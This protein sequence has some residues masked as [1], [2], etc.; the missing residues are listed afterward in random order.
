VSLATPSDHGWATLARRCLDVT[1]ARARSSV[2]QH[3][4]QL[5][6]CRGSRSSEAG[7]ASTNISL[8]QRARSSRGQNIGRVELPRACGT[9]LFCRAAAA[10]TAADV[11]P[12]QHDG[13]YSTRMAMNGRS[14]PAGHQ[15]QVV[16][17]F[18]NWRFK[19]WRMV[20]MSSAVRGHGSGTLD[21]FAVR[22]NGPVGWV[23]GTSCCHLPSDHRCASPTPGKSGTVPIQVSWRSTLATC[24]RLPR[25]PGCLGRRLAW[26]RVWAASSADGLYRGG[27]QVLPA[28]AALKPGF[29]WLAS[30]AS[31]EGAAS[32]ESDS[33]ANAP[34]PRARDSPAVPTF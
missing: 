32:I 15:E 4:R 29:W 30:S 27:H 25:D 20:S 21:R 22:S 11:H 16:A 8:P 6:C 17:C 31:G 19:P 13:R 14:A 26:A 24:L 1:E 33:C 34:G 28:G 3:C 23:A 18:S 12:H 9:S 2:G 5:V 10:G 7:L